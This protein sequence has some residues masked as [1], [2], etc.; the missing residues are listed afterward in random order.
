MKGQNTWSYQPYRPFLWEVGDIYICRIVPGEI[1]LHFEWLPHAFGETKAFWRLRGTEAWSEAAVKD[2]VCDITG[3]TCGA[4]YEF[5]VEAGDKKSRVRLA[6]CGKSV[7]TVVNYLHPED[8]CYAFSGR[9]LCSPTLVKHPDG[10]LLAGMDVFEGDNSQNLELIFRSDDDGK[11]W[12]YVSELMPCFWG[13]LFLHKG[14]LYMLSVSTEYGDLLIGKSTDSGK[15]FSAPVTLLRGANG[16]KGNAG[17][18]KNPQNVVYHKGRIYETLEWGSWK[19]KSYQHAAMVMSCD[20]NADLLN[21]E[22]WHFTPPKVFDPAFAPETAHLPK[23][24]MTIEGTLAVTPEGELFN[25]MRFGDPDGHMI[26]YKVDV[27]DPDAPLEYDHLVPFPANYSKFTIKQDP[28]TGKY[29]TI[30]T[31]IY[32]KTRLGTRNLLSL[33]VSD[34]LKEWKLVCDL[35]D[36]RHEDPQDVG[37]QYVDYEFDG[38]DLIWLCRTAINGAHNFHDANYS[39]FHRIENFRELLR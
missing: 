33:M 8:E 18:H 25:Y 4:D 2:T 34:D 9:Y 37:F 29:V 6:K 3:L 32:D 35:L 7:G 16:K 14:E 39:T 22:S 31:R 21:P 15:T 23:P 36:H 1:T 11:S 19:N 28:I 17:V 5:Y 38:D 10:Y 12:Y 24:N 13:K 26:A 27:N 30:A 20:E